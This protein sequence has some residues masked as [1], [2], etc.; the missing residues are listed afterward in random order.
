ME[1]DCKYTSPATRLN[2]SHDSTISLS[3]LNK[4]YLTSLVLPGS[5]SCR[6]S[7][8]YYIAWGSSNKGYKACCKSSTFGNSPSM[9]SKSIMVASLPNS[10]LQESVLSWETSTTGLP[11]SVC[12]RTERLW[13]RGPNEI[14]SSHDTR[15]HSPRATILRLKL[16]ARGQQH[17]WW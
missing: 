10:F 7:R 13:S 5:E 6:P 2:C 1:I 12:Q 14:D 3:F 15:W 4:V 8:T 9:S 17:Q 11:F 16:A